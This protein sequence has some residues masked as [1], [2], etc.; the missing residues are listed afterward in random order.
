MSYLNW[1]EDSDLIN[2]VEKVYQTLQQALNTTSLKR[3]QA[4][5]VDP[6]SLVFETA[7]TG[8]TMEEWISQETQRQV[9]KTLSNAVGE[10]HQEILGACAGWTNLGIGHPTK[11]DL[12]KS[13][14]SVFAEIKN[15]HN[16]MNDASQR[17]A[18]RRL[19]DVVH[20]YP[21]ANVYLVELIRARK[22]AY[23]EVWVYK[24]SSNPS[25]KK[26]SGELFYAM[27]T[28]DEHAIFDLCRIISQVIAD[29]RS[30]WGSVSS[31]TAGTYAQLT[32]KIGD[33]VSDDTIL[34]YFVDSAFPNS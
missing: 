13:D 14:D 3:L 22:S 10:F 19:L 25:L 12:K 18:H 28:E 15:K 26:I 16:T 5:V 17:E 27:V 20:R 21:K 8:M 33:S 1:I 34:D 4:N 23:D 2:A 7:L 32:A 30:E 6:F 31:K 24:G 11:L 9:Q 29:H